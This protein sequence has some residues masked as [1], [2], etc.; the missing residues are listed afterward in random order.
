MRAVPHAHVGVVAVHDAVRPAVGREEDLEVGALGRLEDVVRRL[1][2]PRVGP[3]AVR[4]AA[5]PFAAVERPTVDRIQPRDRHF[6]A[7]R[8][9]V[10]R[11]ARHVVGEDRTLA[12][13]PERRRCAKRRRGRQNSLHFPALLL[14]V[15]NRWMTCVNGSL[16]SSRRR[17]LRKG[18]RPLRKV[19]RSCR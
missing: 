4:L 5:L 18:H 10:G 8:Q 2:V 1:D 19:F 3:F 16:S 9:L 13:D 12:L 7:G 15:V 17:I 6:L 14:I 11:E